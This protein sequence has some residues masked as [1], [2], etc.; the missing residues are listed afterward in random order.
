[1]QRIRILTAAVALLGLLTGSAYAAPVDF[2]PGATYP[3]DIRIDGAGIQSPGPLMP[4]SCS[5]VYTTPPSAPP[6]PA[7]PNLRAPDADCTD[8]ATS[9]TGI[10][11][12]PANDYYAELDYDAVSGLHTVTV[13]IEVYRAVLQRGLGSTGST[14]TGVASTLEFTI[15][16]DPG[17]PTFGDVAPTAAN[18]HYYDASALLSIIS[19]SLFGVPQAADEPYFGQADNVLAVDIGPGAQCLGPGLPDACCVDAG[20]PDTPPTGFCALDLPDAGIPVVVSCAESYALPVGGGAVV[21][22]A[23]ANGLADSLVSHT[24]Y[25]NVV[26]GH[27]AGFYLQMTSGAL[28]GKI[29]DIAANDDVAETFTVIESMTGVL[30]GDTFAVIASTDGAG[31]GSALGPPQPHGALPAV[32]GVCGDPAGY[33]TSPGFAILGGGETVMTAY[34]AA[35]TSSPILGG[36]ATSPIWAP[37]DQKFD[38][39]GPDGDSDGVP[40]EFDNCETVPNGPDIAGA[41]NFQQD[42]DQDGYG[43]ACDLD[44]DND[45]VV[46][47]TD[48]TALATSFGSVPGDANWNPAVDSDCDGVIGG[49]DFTAFVGAF[50]GTGLSDTS[51]RYCADNLSATGTCPPIMLP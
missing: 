46:G 29:V 48:F 21:G 28:L 49:T 1:M 16:A 20:V 36:A 23:I 4:G 30:P 8:E 50:G 22:L 7:F 12:D 35:F 15:D 37:M 11:T 45:G 43:N 33:D 17:S 13:P 18:G 51:L 26:G 6:F 42:G 25:T 47:G 38:E 40:D 27:A 5:N 44:W 2:S 41:C 39:I 31:T 19:F 14:L 34:S 24:G 32:S 3:R 10:F 9:G